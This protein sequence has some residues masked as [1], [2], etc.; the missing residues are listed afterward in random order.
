MVLSSFSFLDPIVSIKTALFWRRFKNQGGGWVLPFLNFSILFFLLIFLLTQGEKWIII[1]I[2]S[3]IGR[4]KI[5]LWPKKGFKKIQLGWSYNKGF[6]KTLKNV[7]FCAFSTFAASTPLD[8]LNSALW[9]ALLKSTPT[10]TSFSL[11]E[12]RKQFFQKCLMI[13]QKPSSFFKMALLH[14][15]F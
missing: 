9:V 8:D 4:M 2:K 6:F 5:W 12:L 10:P 1:E 11:Q 7:R 13:K 3:A 14:F 15:A